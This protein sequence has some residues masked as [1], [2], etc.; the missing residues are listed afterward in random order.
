MMLR[1]TVIDHL[2]CA[3]IGHFPVD[4]QLQQR[5]DDETLWGARKLGRLP[6]AG[7][8]PQWG[9]GKMGEGFSSLRALREAAQRAAR[10]RSSQQDILM[11]GTSTMDRITLQ[12]GEGPTPFPVCLQFADTF[13]EHEPGPTKRTPPRP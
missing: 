12:N 8:P 11:Q 1:V 7:S 13:A 5:T 9:Q 2:F 10:E 3:S 4:S 6:W